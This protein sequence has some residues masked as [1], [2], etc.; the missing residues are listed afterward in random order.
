MLELIKDAPQVDP[1]RPVLLGKGFE[2]MSGE[3]KMR[4]VHRDSTQDNGV[5]AVGSFR[6]PHWGFASLSGSPKMT[7]PNHRRKEDV[8]DQVESVC[9][10]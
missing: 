10:V 1:I 8:R 7:D 5:W 9:G 2:P 6:E 4:S 3:T